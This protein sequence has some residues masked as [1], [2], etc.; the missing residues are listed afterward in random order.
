MNDKKNKLIAFRANDDVNRILDMQE[1]KTEFI[2]NAINFYIK[3]AQGTDNKISDIE[4]KI[5]DD[6]K[7]FEKNL[8]EKTEKNLKELENNFDKKFGELDA[9]LFDVMR[10]IYHL[11]FALT[12]TDN[13]EKI[14]ESK[15]IFGDTVAGIKQKHMKQN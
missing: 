3:G 12:E 5:N 1:N 14:K 6:F 7:N 2:E 11:H 9:F 8:S 15:K 10:L 13:Q 4:K